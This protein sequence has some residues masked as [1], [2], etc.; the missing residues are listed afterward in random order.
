LEHLNLKPGN[1]IEFVV[2]EEEFITGISAICKSDAG[3]VINK[4]DKT[5]RFIFLQ[6]S[7]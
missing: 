3:F 4:R 1:R 2:D 5:W 6:R 7:T